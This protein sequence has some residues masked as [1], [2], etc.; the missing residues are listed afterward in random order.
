MRRKI[1]LI[2]L[3]VILTGIFPAAAGP[4]SQPRTQE[5]AQQF[6][7]PGLDG[8]VTVRFDAFGIPQVYATTSHDLV[9]AQGFLHAA[10][11]WWQM[12]WFR[13]IGL[14]RLAEIGGSSLIDYDIYMRTLGITQNAQNDLD[15]MAPEVLALLQ[16]YADGVN[17]WIAAKAPRDL[18][19]EYVLLNQ[20]RAVGGV[21]PITEIEPWT[22]LHSAVWLHVL[23]EG[24]S[25]NPYEELVRY[26]LVKTYGADALPLYAPGYDYAGQPLITAPGGAP[27]KSGLI[28]WFTPIPPTPFPRFAEKGGSTP[29]DETESPLSTKTAQVKLISTP[30]LFSGAGLGSNNWVVSG[31]RTASGL[32]LLA[33]DPHLS[34]M[35][36]SIWYEIGLHCAPISPECPYHLSGFGFPGTPLIAIG[37]NDSIAWGTTNVGTDIRDLYVLEINPDNP[38]QYRY[39]GEWLDMEK[40]TETI[41]PW[42]GDPVQIDVWTTRF[43]PVVTDLFESPVPVALRSAAADANRNF[44]GFWRLSQAHNWDDFQAALSLIDMLG[45][46]FVYAD[47]DGNIGYMMTGRVPIRAAGHDG[48]LPV[49]GTTSAFEWQGYVDPAL[50]PR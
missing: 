27:E 43:G 18:A 31:S 20:L 39:E 13:R 4:D 44:E 21:D 26:R 30:R 38:A 9:M 32:P 33:N 25:G 1:L 8:E 50:N 48:S 47:V 10:D 28:P 46:N 15:H 14:G 16:A 6:V 12:D 40:I 35:M 29:P 24:L 34:I 37:H 2:A 36:P 22:P 5:L 11:R 23:A 42:D 45:Q 49:D 7:I 17:A 19:V 41:S 3:I